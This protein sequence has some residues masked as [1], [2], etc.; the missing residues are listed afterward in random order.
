MP[1]EP[2]AT[3]T[4][5]IAVIGGGISGLAAAHLLSAT[6]TVV[7]YEAEKRFGGHART[8]VAGRNGDQPVDTGFIVYN[9]ANYPHLSALFDRL[10]VPVVNSEMSFGVSIDGGRIEYG[11]KSLGAILAQRRN[12]FRPGFIRMIRDIVRFNQTARS[13][14]VGEDMT[15]G[16]LIE[17]M[18][19][20]RWFR[21]YYLTP[22]SGAIWS[23]P[24]Q[25]ILD[26][27]AH[28]LVRFFDNHALLRYSNQHQWLTVKGGSVEY[29][30]RLAV[31]LTRSG[32]DLRPG[33]PVAGVRRTA[34]GA[35]V[36]CFGGDW[37]GFDD[38]VFATHSDDAL[39]LL[40]DPTP[41]ERRALAAVAYQPNLAVLHADS[42]VM[43]RRKSAWSSWVYT[44]RG[45]VP[46][47][48]ISLSYWMNSLQPIPADDPMFVTLNPT[49]PI[50]ET[51]IYDETTFR[52]P[53]FDL[54]ALTAQSVI[55]GMNGKNATWFCGAWMHNGFHED[56]FASAVDVAGAMERQTQARKA[57]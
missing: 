19:L 6:H 47:D 7:L 10:D 43:P 32:V 34:E 22:I 28:A 14:V 38:V 35:E 27:P 49:G 57:A 40:S 36:R 3:A 50:R 55:R 41:E 4:P 30:R 46:T 56:G 33:S 51:L 2:P 21:D 1:F 23:T 31:D 16:G 26:F 48:R 18:R 8:V 9:R 11:L 29:V 52:H 53:V 13:H 12:A 24:T 45:G 17:K 20:G 39:T 5:R 37:E 44:E 42:A 54:G 15:I 25:G